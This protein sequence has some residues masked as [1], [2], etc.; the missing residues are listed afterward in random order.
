MLG[1][2]TVVI[3]FI[4]IS[5]MLFA[6][7]GDVLADDRI[8]QSNWAD[9]DPSLD[10]NPASLFWRDS[11]PTYMDADAHGKPDPRYRTQVR[12][13]WTLKNLYFLFVC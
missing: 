12:T 7:R 4:C 3:G 10:T 1:L 9:S 5:T 2:K 11:L 13:R 6:C 8:I